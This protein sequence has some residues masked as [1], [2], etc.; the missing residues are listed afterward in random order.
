MCGASFDE[1]TVDP[2]APTWDD[3]S[4]AA[5]ADALA[6]EAA[7]SAAPRTKSRRDRTPWPRTRRI[8]F[9]ATLAG[10]LI[11]ALAGFTW[12]RDRP[13]EV[14]WTAQQSPLGLGSM[15]EGGTCHSFSPSADQDVAVAGRLCD[16]GG[17]RSLVVIEF[18]FRS[19]DL[20]QVEPRFLAESLMQGADG[21][22]TGA[23]DTFTPSTS[24]VGS[25]GDFTGRAIVSGVQVDTIGRIIESG[26]RGILVMGAAGDVGD[27]T[28][29]F[30]TMAS[31]FQ[32][33]SPPA[34]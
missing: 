16:I 30:H 34:S 6:A 20:S 14:K 27:V 11:V 19:R 4:A 23:L 25:G 12:Y 17:G 5:A 26:N 22:Q 18:N 15:K 13:P 31:S 9:A 33:A 32:L 8:A 2:L 10:V 1:P 29:A 24:A 7:R 3:P 28:D 21:V